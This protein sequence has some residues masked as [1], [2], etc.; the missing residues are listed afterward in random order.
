MYVYN[1]GS[2]YVFRSLLSL[3]WP[4]CSANSACHL[5]QVLL[6]LLV[7][8][9]PPISQTNYPYN[10]LIYLFNLSLG[11]SY[12]CVFVKEIMTLSMYGCH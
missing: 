5:T 12:L 1:K 8:C 11:P 10:S 4:Q 7:M 9:V 6:L 3:L 2:C